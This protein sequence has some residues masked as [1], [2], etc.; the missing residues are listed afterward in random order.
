MRGAA[1]SPSEHVC[2]RE[3]PDRWVRRAGCTASTARG[4]EGRAAEPPP[5]P[6]PSGGGRPPPIGPHCSM[7]RPRAARV[8]LSPLEIPGLSP[9]LRATDLLSQP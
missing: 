4:C 7:R 1:F 9:L 8:S 5:P 6:T 3:G 2:T